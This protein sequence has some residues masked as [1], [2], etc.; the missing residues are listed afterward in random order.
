MKAFP[1]SDG[2]IHIKVQD[3]DDW[4]LLSRILVDANDED[5]D[6]AAD[7]S[8]RIADGELA[9]DWRDFVLPDLRDEFDESLG[10]VTRTLGEAYTAHQGGPGRVIIVRDAAMDWYGVLNRARL[11]LEARHHFAARGKSAQ[12]DSEKHSARLRDRLY[13]A[14]QSLLLDHALG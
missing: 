7:V 14:L 4:R 3:P 1:I 6:L 13:C 11:A 8:G 2:V 9:D 5:F 10:R 12:A